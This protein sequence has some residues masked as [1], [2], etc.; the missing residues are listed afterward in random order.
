MY[1]LYYLVII[2]K[3]SITRCISGVSRKT[4]QI[5]LVYLNGVYNIS[6]L[7]NND[8]MRQ[9]QF[10]NPRGGGFIKI[11]MVGGKGRD[12][13]NSLK[14]RCLETSGRSGG[15]LVGCVQ[16][17][18]VGGLGSSYGG[19]V[20]NLSGEAVNTSGDG[21]SERTV[22]LHDGT[23]VVGDE[24]SLAGGSV[25]GDMTGLVSGKVTSKVSSLG[26]GVGLGE[27]LLVGSEVGG[28]GELV[29]GG[30]SGGFVVVDGGGVDDVVGRVVD[31]TISHDDVD[32]WGSGS[33]GS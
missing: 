18:E 4:A 15:R 31:T 28:E 9:I 13:N 22:P 17:S 7:K 30:N 33:E 2:E 23:S 24:G 10:S 5:F 3:Y 16:S 21:V 12:A 27:E 26:E 6:H 25:L 32:I 19:G 20:Q 1:Y 11:I 14:L 29:E 8:S